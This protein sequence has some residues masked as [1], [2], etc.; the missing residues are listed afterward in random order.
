MAE[1]AASQENPEA[2]YRLTLMYDT[3]L[4]VG[5]DRSKAVKLLEKAVGKN[6]PATQGYLG[7]IYLSDIRDAANHK[8]GLN[9]LEKAADQNVSNA[10]YLLGVNHFIGIIFG[11]RDY[12]KALQYF[13]TV[14]IT[15]TFR[16]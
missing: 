9:L 3:G 1:K 13:S 6:H 12:K 11:K 8:K 16:L 7:G 4:G 15:R 14:S 10:Q 2:Q 5:R